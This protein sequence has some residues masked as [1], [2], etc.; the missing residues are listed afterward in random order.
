MKLY[1]DLVSPFV[2][3]AMVT[4]LECDLQDR[5]QLERELVKPSEEN[6]RLAALSAIGKIP[7]LVTE[8][9]HAI[10]DSRVIMEYLVH[11]SGHKELLPGDGVKR[12]RILTLQALGQG[13]AE[14]AVALRYETATRPAELKW[15]EF[16]T[17]LETR[18]AA[19]VA[20]LEQN[21]ASDLE[22]VNAGAIAVAVAL[23]YIDF[24]LP[25]FAWRTSAPRLQVAIAAIAERDSFKR[26]A[27][28]Q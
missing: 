14:A 1:G 23:C 16:V 21:W 10:Y 11:A 18:L 28:T 25:N 7:I 8:H 17:R 26:T 5:V 20:D 19:I 6:E 2:R 12:F 27:L 15:N 13:L 22:Q 3:M 4:A 24:R 9:G